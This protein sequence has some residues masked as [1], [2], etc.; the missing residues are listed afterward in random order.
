M[1]I[2]D[3]GASLTFVFSGLIQRT[4]ICMDVW[5]S[6][7]PKHQCITCTNMWTVHS[8]SNMSI[9]TKSVTMRVKHTLLGEIYTSS[10]T[11]LHN[12][13]KWDFPFCTHTESC[14]NSQPSVTSHLTWFVCRANVLSSASFSSEENIK[15]WQQ[16]GNKWP[17]DQLSPAVIIMSFAHFLILLLQIKHAFKY[18]NSCNGTKLANVIDNLAFG[19]L[20]SKKLQSCCTAYD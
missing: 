13:W 5:T 12:R 16:N 9:K 1:I 14:C 2:S 10:N 8:S 15:W 19:T 17:I 20:R 3:N 18:R 11:F 4:F 6:V 7:W